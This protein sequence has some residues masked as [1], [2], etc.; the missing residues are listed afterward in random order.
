MAYVPKI[1]ELA[2]AAHGDC[3]VTAP[4]VFAMD[5]LAIVIGKGTP[6]VVLEAARNCPTVAIT[7]Y[8]TDTGKKVYP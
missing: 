5:D 4:D 2:C 7:V 3:V 8:D 1:D 6:E